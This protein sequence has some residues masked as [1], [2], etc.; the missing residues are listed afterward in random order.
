MDPN[1]IVFEIAEHEIT[2]YEALI[3]QHHQEIEGLLQKIEELR[4]LVILDAQGR[5]TSFADWVA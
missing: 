3:E 5:N 4:S 1:L 2:Q